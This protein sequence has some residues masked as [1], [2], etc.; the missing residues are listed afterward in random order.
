MNDVSAITPVMSPAR[1]FDGKSPTMIL[2]KRVERS[3]GAANTRIR[4]T[5]CVASLRAALIY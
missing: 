1:Q 5:G 2:T 4:A 3:L